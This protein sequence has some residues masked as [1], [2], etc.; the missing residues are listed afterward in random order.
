MD[1]L[2]KFIKNGPT[3]QELD[4]AKQNIT[5]SFP[6]R[7]ASNNNIVD[8]L[9]MIGFYLL[10]LNYLD[11]FTTKVSSVTVRQIQNAFER[12]IHPNKMVTVIVGGPPA[13]APKR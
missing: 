2:S 7:I 10:P 6:L 4:S 11:T 13:T 12:R 3:E 5:G 9:S 8:Y 1:V